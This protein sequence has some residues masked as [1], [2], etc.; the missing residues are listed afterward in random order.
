MPHENQSIDRERD[1]A[2]EQ[3]RA[4]QLNR[5]DYGATAEL[6]PGSVKKGRGR[7]TYKRFDTAAA[8][9]RF[10]VEEMPA[11]ALLGAYLEVGEG[12]FGIRDIRHLYEN[13]AYP[14][15]RLATAN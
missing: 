2:Q 7:V 4:Q 9:L 6:F 11:A 5:F 3:E 10:A 14:L 8:A 12:R 1:Q 15:K 13:T